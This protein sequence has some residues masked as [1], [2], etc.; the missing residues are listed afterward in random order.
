MGWTGLWIGRQFPT[1]HAAKE[2]PRKPASVIVAPISV[3][4]AETKESL[5]PIEVE[6]IR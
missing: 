2:L 3:E 5:P 4:P 6:K 1:S